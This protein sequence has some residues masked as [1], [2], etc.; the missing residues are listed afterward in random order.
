MQSPL[1]LPYSRLQYHLCW[2]CHSRLLELAKVDYQ[3]KLRD[4]M[5]TISIKPD[6]PEEKVDPGKGYRAKKIPVA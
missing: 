6:V 1:D 4:Q 2:I 5:V 3:F